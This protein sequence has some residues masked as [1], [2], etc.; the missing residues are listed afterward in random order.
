MLGIV[1]GIGICCQ[2]MGFRYGY[3]SECLISIPM[4]LLCLT[5]H[6]QNEAWEM[7]LRRWG[8]LSFGAYLVHPIFTTVM[9]VVITKM[10]IEQ[11]AF[12]FLL[13]QGIAFGASM[14]FAYMVSC[15]GRR[16]PVLRHIQA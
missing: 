15:L 11:T 9:R 6:F 13:D 14:A 7:R 4:C 3:L 2:G 16:F 8:M 5:V 1:L 12:V 10:K